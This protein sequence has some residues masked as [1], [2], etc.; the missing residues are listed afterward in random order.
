MEI[1]T[2][3]SLIPDPVPSQKQPHPPGSPCA[4]NDMFPR[5]SKRFLR[6][7]AAMCRLNDLIFLSSKQASLDILCHPRECHLTF[8]VAQVGS[9]EHDNLSNK[10]RGRD[11]M[12]EK[13]TKTRTVESSA[14]RCGTTRATH[15]AYDYS[16]A[17][18]PG[19]TGCLLYTSPSPR[20]QLSSRMPSSA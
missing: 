3:T 9:E 15:E 14:W 4:C 6:S 17:D 11:K 18:V 8:L 16:S 19:L 2:R 20:D 12:D 13:E 5:V 7:G 1:R 10:E